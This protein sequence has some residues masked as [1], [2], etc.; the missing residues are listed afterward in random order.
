LTQLISLAKGK[1]LDSRLRSAA[2]NAVITIQNRI[3]D[4]K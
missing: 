3:K 2:A 4:E 1:Q